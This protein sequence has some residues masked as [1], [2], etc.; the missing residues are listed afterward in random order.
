MP[1]PHLW[2]VTSRGLLVARTLQ[3]VGLADPR[4]AVTFI[5]S[6]VFLFLLWSGLDHTMIMMNANTLSKEIA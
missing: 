6:E 4:P 2:P 3:R 1:S 5:D